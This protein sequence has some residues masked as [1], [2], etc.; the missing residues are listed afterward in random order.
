MSKSAP[1]DEDA[2]EVK[3]R[4]ARAMAG[5]ESAMTSLIAEF[6]PA[7]SALAFSITRNREG[8]EDVA[9]ETMEIWRRHLKQFTGKQTYLRPQIR[10]WLATT[11]RR[12]AVKWALANPPAPNIPDWFLG[13]L[14][15]TKG[16]PLA[17]ILRAERRKSISDCIDELADPDARV[18]RLWLA[19]YTPETLGHLLIFASKRSRAEQFLQSAVAKIKACMSI[20]GYNIAEG[21]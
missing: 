12:L 13:R 15:A 19:G 17:G 14:E 2:E 7:V 6:C 4:M 16:D 20:K 3:R 10:T 1:F 21:W 8:A 5:D 9:I 11:A 18:F